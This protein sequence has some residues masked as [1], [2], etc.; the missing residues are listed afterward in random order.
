MQV[1]P[2]RVLY[3][4]ERVLR[5]Y[6]IEDARA[7]ALLRVSEPAWHVY[8]TSAQLE[9]SSSHAC[10]VVIAPPLGRLSKLYYV[11]TP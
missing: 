3:G 9:I 8:C 11:L 5:P 7:A 6:A 10:S 4:I 1:R 2:R